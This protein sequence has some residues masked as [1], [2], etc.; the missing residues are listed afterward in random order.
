MRYELWWWGLTVAYH[1]HPP[2]SEWCL[3]QGTTSNASITAYLY[4]TTTTYLHFH[5]TNRATIEAHTCRMAS[6]TEVTKHLNTSRLYSVYKSICEVLLH[7][8]LWKLVLLQYSTF[9]PFSI[10]CV[11]TSIVL[12]LLLSL[13]F[14]LRAPGKVKGL[15]GFL[16]LQPPPSYIPIIISAEYE[17]P[18]KIQPDWDLQPLLQ[19][20]FSNQIPEIKYLI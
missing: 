7:L 19:V 17:Q 10:I 1:H 5:N 12:Q 2:L 11:A 20:H 6:G 9:S 16:L 3:A 18:P 15:G 14:V 8:F 13:V 4:H